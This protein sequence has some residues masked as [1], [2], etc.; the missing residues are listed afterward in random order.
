M[1]E[2][3]DTSLPSINKHLETLD[4]EKTKKENSLQ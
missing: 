4:L 2:K 3:T 1:T